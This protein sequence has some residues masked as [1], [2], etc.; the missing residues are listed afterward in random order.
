M[1][2]FLYDY[3]LV[4]ETLNLVLALVLA[5]IAIN[6]LKRNSSSLGKGAVFLVFGFFSVAILQF[7]ELYN[8]LNSEENFIIRSGIKFAIMLLISIGLLLE[9]RSVTRSPYELVFEKK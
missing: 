3:R 6:F 1:K 8:V 9:S 5:L 7:L 2:E 4:I